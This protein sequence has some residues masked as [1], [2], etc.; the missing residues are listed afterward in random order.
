VFKLYIVSL[1]Y[2]KCPKSGEF[3]LVKFRDTVDKGIVM[4]LGKCE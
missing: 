2:L 3:Y 4:I 1:I